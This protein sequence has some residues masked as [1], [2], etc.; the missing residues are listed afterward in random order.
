MQ[1]HDESAKKPTSLRNVYLG[2]L[3]GRTRAIEP[4]TTDEMN[5][6]APMSSPIARPPLLVLMLANVEKRSGLPLPKARKVTPATLSLSPRIFAIV[7]RF[8]V[9]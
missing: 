6:A 7:L 9:K 8:G 3:K 2:T 4:A 5:P 1:K